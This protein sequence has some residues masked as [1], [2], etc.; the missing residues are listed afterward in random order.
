MDVHDRDHKHYSSKYI[1]IVQRYDND[2]CYFDDVSYSYKINMVNFKDA[3]PIIHDIFV[4][5]KIYTVNE[6]HDVIS[7]LGHEYDI[8]Y[9]KQRYY[10]TRKKHNR[11]DYMIVERL[12]YL[13]STLKDVLD[14]IE[15]F[16]K[17]CNKF[18]ETVERKHLDNA[19]KAL[20][21]IEEY[22]TTSSWSYLP[23]QIHV[24]YNAYVITLIEYENRIPYVYDDNSE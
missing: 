9:D 21:D 12:E 4:G 7:Q 20:Y 14:I 10:D 3:F 15:L 22:M 8:V 18:T 11:I 5:D 24:K 19:M 17:R 1:D 16:M 13:L 2:V 23:A 6:I